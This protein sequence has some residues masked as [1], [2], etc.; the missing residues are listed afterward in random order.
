[1]ICIWTVDISCWCGEK[2]SENKNVLTGE[3]IALPSDLNTDSKIDL[4]D[5]DI[6]KSDS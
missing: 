5:F 2:D 6:L 4:T 1:M 3:P